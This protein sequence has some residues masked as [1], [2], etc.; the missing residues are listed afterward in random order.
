MLQEWAQGQG[1]PLPLYRR[2]GPERSAA[3]AGVSRRG[4]GRG[5]RPGRGTGSSKRIAERAAAELA[6]DE[7]AAPAHGAAESGA[8]F[9]RRAGGASAA[10]YSEA[11]TTLRLRRGHRVRPTSAN[12]RWSTAWS[13]ARS[14]SSRRRCRR[15][16]PRAR[17]RHD[18]VSADPAGRHAR[19]C[20]RRAAAS[21]RRWSTPPGK[22]R[23]GADVI[24]LWSSMQPRGA[25]DGR[26]TGHRVA[27]ASASAGPS[28]C[29]TRWT[30]S[31]KPRLLALA[32]DSRRERRLR[33][34]LHGL[35]ADRRRRRRPR[36]HLWRRRCRRGR[37]SIRKTSLGHAGT[38]AGRRD[39]PREAV[40]AAA[41]GTAVFGRRRDRKLDASQ[42]RQR[43]HRPGDLR[44][45]RGAARHRHRQGR[46]AAQAHRRDWRARRCRTLF[47]RRV[48]LFLFVKVREKWKEDPVFFRLHGLE[49]PR[50]FLRPADQPAARITLR[51]RRRSAG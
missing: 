4:H 17:H 37:G 14:A 8:A 31:T 22:G 29:S 6:A 3:R 30:R 1:L 46:A 32:R 33:P 36:A 35:G 47:D 20:S 26:G 34:R 16:G 38:A 28:W 7:G 48:H 13:A 42:G 40:L 39:H 49:I 9:R 27:A 44:R 51:R 43:A 12:R 19:A 5:F 45:A 15:P 41:A 23:R 25:D 50:A 24:V 11:A 10:G 21:I 2:D 18:R